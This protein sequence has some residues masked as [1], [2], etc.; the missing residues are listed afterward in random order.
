[1]V[2]FYQLILITDDVILK[3]Y[4]SLCQK[5]KCTLFVWS[6]VAHTR[7][8]FYPNKLLWQDSTPNPVLCAIPPRGKFYIV[9]TVLARSGTNL[10]GVKFQAYLLACLMSTVIQSR[11]P[12]YCYNCR[13]LLQSVQQTQCLIPKLWLW[14]HKGN[15][16]TCISEHGGN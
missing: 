9:R 2:Y 12:T 13:Q 10:E 4:T 16:C 7:A 5:A 15:A 8:K 3:L 11:E 14:M 6:T 1:M